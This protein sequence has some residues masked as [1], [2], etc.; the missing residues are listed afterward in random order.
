MLEA[1]T[2][3]LPIK[4][5]IPEY[6]NTLAIPIATIR[7]ESKR[8]SF[9]LGETIYIEKQY[10]RIG[11]LAIFDISVEG[12]INLWEIY[13]KMVSVLF[14][15]FA[16]IVDG[17]LW[18][19][20]NNDNNFIL[21][22]E[23]PEYYIFIDSRWFKENELKK[24]WVFKGHRGFVTFSVKEKKILKHYLVILAHVKEDVYIEYEFQNGTII[25][26]VL[27]WLNGPLLLLQRDES[28]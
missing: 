12:E 25:S 2:T 5:H 14:N 17:H 13:N 19:K 28:C 21:T 8:R 15:P 1:T 4:I 16:E 27:K 3:T 11:D 6:V 7:I 18:F 26:Y 9:P 20:K 22:M 10:P 23:H 24:V